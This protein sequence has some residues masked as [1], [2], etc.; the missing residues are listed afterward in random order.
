MHG[1]QMFIAVA[2]MVLAELA[3]RIALTLQH[4]GHRHVRLL[5]PLLRAGHADL[6]H[7]GTDRRLALM[8]EDLTGAYTAAAELVIGPR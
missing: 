6:G 1:R 7:A 4:G 5:P 8:W 2:L 3:G